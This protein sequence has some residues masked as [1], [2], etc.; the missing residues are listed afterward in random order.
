MKKSK[1]FALAA[2]ALLLISNANIFAH[3]FIEFPASR[4]KIGAPNNVGNV[5][6]EPQSLEAPKGY[7]ESG[8][9]DG[10]IASAG[11]L[12]G[13]ILDEQTANR[14]I[15]HDI[16]Q[17]SMQISWHFTAR[18]RATQWRYYITKPG[19]N[20]N[21]PLTRADFQLL[22][23]FPYNGVLPPEKI[24]HTI[25]IPKTHTGYHVILGV[26]DIYDTANAFYNVVDVNI[27]GEGGATADTQPPTAPGKPT[28]SNIG[29]TSATISFAGSTDNVGVAG[30]DIINTQTGRILKEH[31]GTVVG[32]SVIT[33]QITGLT[34]NSSYSVAVRAYD[35]AGNNS[36]MSP[37]TTYKTLQEHTPD[38]QAPT[39]VANIHSMGN[40]ATSIDLMWSEST[41]NVGVTEYKVFNAINNQLFISTNATRF[42]HTGLI[43]NTDY[44]YYIIAYDAA[45]NASLRSDV[46]TAK[47]VSSGHLPDNQAP[48]VPGKPTVSN[49]D[50]TT[51]SIS[52]TGSTDNVAVEAYEVMDTQTSTVLATISNTNIN[53]KARTTVVGRLTGLTPGKSYTIAVKAYDANANVSALSS[54]TSF[55]TKHDEGVI[56][57]SPSPYNPNMVYPNKGTIVTHEGN[58]YE[59]L[60]YINRDTYPKVTDKNGSNTGWKLIAGP[61]LSTAAWNKDSTYN[62][63]DEVAHNGKTWV[64][65]YWTKGNEPG[66]DQWGPWQAK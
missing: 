24:S 61:G 33:E 21:K 36:G 2:A 57:G 12:F 56:P 17:G 1:R 60:W 13:G 54:S 52:F 43:S 15:K 46:F 19:W 20:P 18:H 29:T 51:A 64:A 66:E 10:K 25:N 26:W 38:T 58:T 11:G 49:I 7:P 4:A 65:K 42:L 37:A 55:T 16:K 63:G 34:S 9:A 53:A 6:Y 14:W 35:A 44:S 30:Y 27:A 3:G 40:T 45:G 50:K 62:A 28:V 59:S 48:S 47:T 5:M 39:K 32:R 8:P 41:D 23:T 22:A 31:R